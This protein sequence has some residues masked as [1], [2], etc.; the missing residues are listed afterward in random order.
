MIVIDDQL[1]LLSRTNVNNKSFIFTHVIDDAWKAFLFWCIS[2]R[3]FIFFNI[4]FSSSLCVWNFQ[5]EY[6]KVWSFFDDSSVLR[7]FENFLIIFELLSWSLIKRLKISVLLN[8]LYKIYKRFIASFRI[9]SLKQFSLINYV[10]CQWRWY[11]FKLK[12][13]YLVIRKFFFFIL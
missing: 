4:Q 5:L 10:Q 2:N 11:S 3:W 7:D 12:H 9:K 6:N 13:V 8:N 1:H